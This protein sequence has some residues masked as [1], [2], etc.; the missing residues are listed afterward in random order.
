MTKEAIRKFVEEALNISAVEDA[1]VKILSNELDPQDIAREIWDMYE[2]EIIEAAAGV[3][4]ESFLP[5]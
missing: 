2:D 1:L 3:A 5:F 4:A